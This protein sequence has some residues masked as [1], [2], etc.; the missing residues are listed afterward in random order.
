MKKIITVFVVVL[1]AGQLM[2]QETETATSLSNT[3]IVRNVSKMD[4][5]GK[6]YNNVKVTLRSVTSGYNTKVKVTIVDMSGRSVWKKTLHNSFLWVFDEGQIQVGQPKFN[7]I[8]IHKNT[9]GSY[10]G[11]IREYEGIYF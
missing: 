4:V 10:S 1:M 3:K 6:I 11:E 7:K 5:E 2:A 9:S 8:V